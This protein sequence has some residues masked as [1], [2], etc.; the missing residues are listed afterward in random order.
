MTH[1]EALAADDNDQGAKDKA[2]TSTRVEDSSA[3]ARMTLDDLRALVRRTDPALRRCLRD[4]SP[5]PPELEEFRTY[6]AYNRIALRRREALAH[7]G[8]HLTGGDHR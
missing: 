4:L 8:Q 5:A 3:D 7:L 1:D 2:T 6:C